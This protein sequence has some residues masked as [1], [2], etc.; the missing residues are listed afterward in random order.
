MAKESTNNIAE[1]IENKIIDQ[2]TLGSGAR[3]ITFKPEK[4]QMGAD[5]VVE[6][7]ELKYKDEGQGDLE[8]FS[9]HEEIFL[10]QKSIYKLYYQGGLISK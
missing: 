1:E 10:E 7:R 5:L 3:L 8:N 4:S 9:G 6:K 2:I